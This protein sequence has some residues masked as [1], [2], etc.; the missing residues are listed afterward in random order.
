MSAKSAR[1][2]RFSTL[3]L[4]AIS[5]F[6]LIASAH[7]AWHRLPRNGHMLRHSHATKAPKLRLLSFSDAARLAFRQRVRYV[8]LLRQA[9]AQAAREQ[10]AFH[11]EHATAMNDRFGQPGFGERTRDL[12][13]MLF[14]PQANAAGNG[15]LP[16]D[17]CDLAG[18]GLYKGDKCIYGGF[19]SHYRT[20][21]KLQP[22]QCLNGARC[23]HGNGELCN[24]AVYGMP[25]NSNGACIS[26][27]F[28]YVSTQLCYKNMEK[29]QSEIQ[30]EAHETAQSARAFF[31]LDQC[32][33]STA[34]PTCAAGTITR[35]EAED[36]TTAGVWLDKLAEYAAS[37]ED[38]AELFGVIELYK[39]NGW[40]IP[41]TKY[42]RDIVN[43]ISGRLDPSKFE[44]AVN[45]VV[46]G[47]KEVFAE[48]EAHCDQHLSQDVCNEIQNYKPG[49][50]DI[51]KRQLIR[52][53]QRRQRYLAQYGCANATVRNTLEHQECVQ[54]DEKI[55]ALNNQAGPIMSS[56]PPTP[57]PPPP[58]PAPHEVD[59][60]Y[61]CSSVFR[62]DAGLF[63]PAAQCSVCL[64][65]NAANRYGYQE[66]EL[67][68]VTSDPVEH[69]KL[70]K[71]AEEFE[72][73]TDS[74]RWK[75][76]LS[77]MALVCGD[78]VNGAH[79][80]TAETMAHYVEAFGQCDSKKYDWPD[81]NL[82]NSEGLLSDVADVTSKS[83]VDDKPQKEGWKG[84]FKEIDTKFRSAYG[85][86]L[87]QV[88]PLFCNSERFKKRWFGLYYSGNLSKNWQ[89]PGVTWSSNAV[90]GFKA[91]AR[92]HFSQ[93][94]VN[95]IKCSGDSAD[96]CNQLKECMTQAID[97]RE[98]LFPDNEICLS[99][100]HPTSAS[101]L[102]TAPRNALD[103]MSAAV[104]ADG[105]RCY[106]S[107]SHSTYKGEEGWSY[108]MSTHMSDP[109]YQADP[110]VGKTIFRELWKGQFDQTPNF[111]TFVC[112][113]SNAS[114]HTTDFAP[115]E[116]DLNDD[117]VIYE[118][119]SC[120][121]PAETSQRLNSHQPVTK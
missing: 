17:P 113:G 115:V 98:R 117:V 14:M 63:Q 3:A 44:G 8:H 60:S 10:I 114:C 100:K 48:E 82:L 116:E 62:D 4:I 89:G 9:V 52:R 5:T 112:N 80:V 94:A 46:E 78:S 97:Y 50:Y 102:V 109:A 49:D 43:G 56:L 107:N 34:N 16:G 13:A 40:P 19:T 42:D 36:P 57:P 66:D 33:L 38:Y 105:S 76:L 20:A 87:M 69:K 85:V 118:N 110:T 73:Y 7:A 95:G 99:T 77:T 96:T 111:G 54:L 91:L 15:C 64:S 74:T 93:D 75:A 61:G 106:V 31:K 103:S 108:A 86:N 90:R 30:Y 65:E 18:R 121:P 92:K 1:L 58:T 71:R 59:Q 27:H 104:I 72:T 35:E 32:A 2:Q 21:G 55:A 120:R 83:P 53:E 45:S 37:D 39:K 29:R 11:S 23:P 67:A 68:S 41:K 84:L 47:V 28:Q 25:V 24:P 22:F 51:H 81:H 88:V 101:D 26:I 6:S 70:V 12:Y 79:D 119:A